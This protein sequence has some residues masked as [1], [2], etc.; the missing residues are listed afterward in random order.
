MLSIRENCSLMNWIQVKN[1]YLRKDD[2]H[3][4]VSYSLLV[5]KQPAKEIKTENSFHFGRKSCK[6]LCSNI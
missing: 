6:M 4:L 3:L 1:P 2:M 5:L